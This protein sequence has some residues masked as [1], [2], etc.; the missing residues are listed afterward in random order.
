ML[1][2]AFPETDRRRADTVR[3]VRVVGAPGVGVAGKTA[4]RTAVRSPFGDDP[5]GES[6]DDLEGI[7]RDATVM[8]G[9]ELKARRELGRD[10]A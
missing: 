1:C 6:V 4:I 9:E 3:R 8:L 2:A 10:G 7:D 5:C